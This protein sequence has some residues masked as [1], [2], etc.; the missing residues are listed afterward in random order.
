[1]KRKKSRFRILISVI[2][3]TILKLVSQF[4]FNVNIHN[5]SVVKMRNIQERESRET[6]EEI[7]RYKEEQEKIDKQR[8]LDNKK[9]AKTNSP[10][11]GFS[12]EKVGKNYYIFP[13]DKLYEMVKMHG[14]YVQFKSE[15]EAIDAGYEERPAS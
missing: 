10:V 12:D 8:I 15:Q 7:K 2:L 5:Q 4:H 1:M 3:A 13:A 6:Q 11:R 9:V 14:E